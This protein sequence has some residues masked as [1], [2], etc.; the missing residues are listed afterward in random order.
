MKK[1]LIIFG[2][3]V[4]V[5]LLP[6][7]GMAISPTRDLLLGLTPDNQILALADKIDQNR[8]SSEQ[9]DSK[10]SELQSTI[11]SQQSEIANYR[12]QVENVK[13]ETTKSVQ[14]AVSNA[15]TE[16]SNSE[17]KSECLESLAGWEKRLKEIPKDEEK[18]I[19]RHK[20][21]ISADAFEKNCKETAK[22][23]L[24]RTKKKV[25]QKKQ[26]CANL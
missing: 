26:E 22:N 12:E 3:V 2:I 9:T 15:I 4:A 19:E 23:D 6:V 18:C 7:L 20:D 16:N 1:S 17:K 10:I 13:S 14:S 24:E 21:D 25:D 8:V 11:D 5:V